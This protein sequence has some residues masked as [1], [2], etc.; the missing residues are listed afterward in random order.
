MEYY[1]L[2][3]ANI[4]RGKHYLSEAASD[5]YERARDRVAMFVGCRANDVIFVRN[6]TEALNLV[7]NGLPLT[8]S[9]L[10][11]G[12]LDA[13]HSHL[14]PWAR[15]ARLELVRV[16]RSGEIDLD[17]YARLVRAH[18]R[19]VAITSCSNVTG[20]YVDLGLLSSMASEAGAIVVVD[21]AQSLPHRRID[22]DALPIDF[23][24]F[25]AH[26]ML[27]PSGIGCLVG[28]QER[29]EEIAPV[30]LGGGM[31]DRVG[32]D[33]TYQARKLPQRLEAGTPAIEAALGFAAALEYLEEL[34]EERVRDHD[35][36]LAEALVLGASKRDYLVML[37]GAR[38]RAAVLTV[39]IRGCEDLADVARSLSDSYG[40]MC[41]SGH[42]C[43]Q[44]YVDACVSGDVLRASA[45]LYNTTADVEALFE[46]LDELVPEVAR[47]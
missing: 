6:T 40:I 16:D 34:G 35:V 28:R 12:F 36:L 3:T 41:R 32:E 43:A 8:S 25:S 45:Y 18:P 37:G 14:L 1:T 21:A 2:H 4:H 47:R 46:A 19:L 10:V 31:L 11:V 22:F 38:D 23:L 20:A 7:A 30:N 13:H 5:R 15:R 44:P 42:L 9:D 24:A 29:L 33:G 27:G 26:K 39:A 17:H